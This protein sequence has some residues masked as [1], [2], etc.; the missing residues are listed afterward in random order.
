MSTRWLRA[1]EAARYANVSLK[2]L[3]AAVRAGD[4]KVARIGTGRNVRFCEDWIDEWLRRAAGEAPVATGRS[5]G[6]GPRE[7]L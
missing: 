3:Y 5:A 1:P 7:H 6:V 2:F 4:L